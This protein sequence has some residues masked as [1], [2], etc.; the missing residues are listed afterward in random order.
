MNVEKHQVGVKWKIARLKDHPQQAAM[1]GDVSE[2][3]LDALAADIRAHGLRHPVEVLPDGTVVGGH[4]RVRAAKKLGWKEIAVVVRRDLA[5]AGESA[6]EAHFIG[7][8]FHRRQLT[9]LA[10]ARCLKRLMEL[11]QGKPSGRF[12]FAKTEELK[13]R[14]G[15][16]MGVSLRSVNRYLLVL[17]TPPEVQACFDAGGLSL[18]A[19]GKV[20]LLP[21]SVQAEVARRIA[22]GERPTTVVGELT[23]SP[24]DPADPVR[25]FAR[26]V[27]C[28]RKE[29]P[30]LKG[31]TARISPGRL[32]KSAH[33]LREAVA[34]L[35]E[36]APETP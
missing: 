28:L 34:V 31:Q 16:R 24:T 11:E 18:V 10:R 22:A 3:E 20:A 6:V 19:A 5:A 15:E 30:R 36:F 35:A 27:S 21:K 4:Q 13:A 2:G 14:I 1:F 33:A 23:R 32:A 26:L 7:D 8:N 29:V 17:A 9:P 25:A 12:G